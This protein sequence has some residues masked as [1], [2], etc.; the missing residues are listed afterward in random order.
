MVKF[1]QRKLVSIYSAAILA[2]LLGLLYS[3]QAQAGYEKSRH[4]IPLWQILFDNGYSCS[5]QELDRFKNLETSKLIDLLSDKGTLNSDKMCVATALQEIGSPAI[6][7]LIYALKHPDSATRSAVAAILGNIRP[8]AKQA[9][10]ALLEALEDKDIYV[11]K[12]TIEALGEIVTDEREPFLNLLNLLNGEDSEVAARAISKISIN[13]QDQA[14]KM[15]INEIIEMIYLLEENKKHID[16][17]VEVSVTEEAID[18]VDRTTRMLKAEQKSRIFERSLNWCLQNKWFLAIA[19]YLF[20][21]PLLW[22]LLL[23]L[24]PLWLLRINDAL[25]PYD[26]VLAGGS[27]WGGFPIS[28]RS[29]IFLKFF[30]YRDR[31]LD[32]WISKNIGLLQQQ[33][34]RIDTVKE[35]QTYVPMPVTLDDRTIANLDASNLQPFLKKERFCLSIWGEGGIGKT[36]LACRLAL[37]GMV[38]KLCTH[39]M[40]PIFIEPDFDTT[41]HKNDFSLLERIGRQL[42]DLSQT[43]DPISQDW[44]D[45]LL[46]KQRILVIFDGVSEMNSDTRDRIYQDSLDINAAIV[47]SRYPEKLQRTTIASLKPLRIAGNRLSSFMEAYLMQKKKRDLFNDPEF[48]TICIQLSEMVGDR[49]VTVLLAKLYTEQAIAAKESPNAIDLP[50]TIPELMLAYVRELNRNVDNKQD[51]RFVCRDAKAIAWAC[52]Q[53]TYRS[54]SITIE[55]AIAIL[56]GD[57]ADNRLYYL[58]AKLRLIQTAGSGKDRIR[59]SLDPVAEYLAGLHL[60]ELYGKNE[61]RWIDFL[62]KA[63][64]TQTLDSIQ[65]FLLAVQ[66]CYLTGIPGATKQDFLPEYITDLY[67]NTQPVVPSQPVK[68]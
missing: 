41:S 68:R 14:G 35:R 18:I 7:E 27:L 19:S 5:E 62:D 31:V 3:S 23:R 10:P 40:L 65:S 55:K 63:E 22:T 61:S 37:W 1:W 6:N 53:S 64:A 36:T 50:R 51:D 39:R 42:Q 28:L 26:F 2:A 12:T 48:F 8:P 21:F 17:D 29:F 59:F 9:I 13:L 47:T 58:E 46:K 34:H 16:S 33:F 66:E 24:H 15:E 43:V 44:L 57:D 49:D 67:P 38:G 56:G 11:R 60:V 45:R 54:T 30:S 52:L 4:R 32:A 20:G 25:K